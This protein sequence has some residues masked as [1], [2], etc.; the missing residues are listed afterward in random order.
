MAGSF[1]YR[2]DTQEGVARDGRS[3]AVPG[4]PA[5]ADEE[6]LIVADGTSCRHQIA[7]GHLGARR[8]MSRGFWKSRW[9]R[10]VSNEH[11][12]QHGT[13]PSPHLPAPGTCDKVRELI[14]TGELPSGKESPERELCE[15]FGV[16][17]T[18]LREALK[19][20]AADQLVGA[21]AQSRGPG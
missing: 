6:T 11:P 18:P 21:S 2:T 15:M 9:T 3:L 17:R 19:V 20:L 16:S 10:S 13:P 14:V 1:G 8:S 4:D 7:D 5:R 12:C